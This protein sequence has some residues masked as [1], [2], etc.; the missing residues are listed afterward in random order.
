[1]PKICI[2]YDTPQ[3]PGT[4]GPTVTDYT[5][6]IGDGTQTVFPLQHDLDHREVHVLA[7]DTANGRVRSDY[8]V[9]L[10][11]ENRAT[12]RFTTAPAA[13]SVRVRVLAVAP[14]E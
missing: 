11:T 8:T 14:A 5:T 12:L 9:N 4:G 7:Y 2:E 3:Q 6:T 1:M 10:D 13:G